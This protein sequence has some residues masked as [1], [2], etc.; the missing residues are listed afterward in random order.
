[1]L[2]SSNGLGVVCEGRGA[3]WGRCMS[4]SYCTNCRVVLAWMGSLKRLGGRQLL[5]SGSTPSDVCCG[6]RPCS[7][8]RDCDSATSSLP[9]IQF[10]F[11]KPIMSCEYDCS[12]EVCLLTDQNSPASCSRSRIS[13]H[14]SLA[15]WSDSWIRHH[16]HASQAGQHKPDLGAAVAIP[17]A[18][19]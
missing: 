15:W 5:T 12:T 14:I 6:L 19:E 13:V 9:R 4:P 17:I 2:N 3:S 1:M 16:D 18:R 11:T 7:V 10:L 8:S